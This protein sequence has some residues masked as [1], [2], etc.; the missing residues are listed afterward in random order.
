ME[1]PS[2]T[3]KHAA[4]RFREK[5]LQHSPAHGHKTHSDLHTVVCRVFEQDGEEFKARMSRATLWFTKFAM[6]LMAATIGACRSTCRLALRCKATFFKI[7]LAMSS[8][9]L[10]L[11]VSSRAAQMS[12]SH[13]HATRDLITEPVFVFES[14]FSCHSCHLK[15]RNIN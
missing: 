13:G 3:L 1:N 10:A 14:G 15:R 2:R 9:K 12:V 11:M 4:Q 6:N 5:V 7:I 8:E